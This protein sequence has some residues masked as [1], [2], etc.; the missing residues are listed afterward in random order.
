MDWVFIMNTFKK[1]LI[2]AG[3]FFGA[4]FTPLVEKGLAILILVLIDCFTGIWASIIRRRDAEEAGDDKK[5]AEN[6]ITSRKLRKTIPKFISYAIAL[7]VSLIF[8]THFGF[9]ILT[10]VAFFLASVEVK[11][12]FENLKD[13]TKINFIESISNILNNKLN[14]FKN[15][16]EQ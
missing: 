16:N 1:L 2:Y 8:T 5:I 15:K 14:E 6:L 11:S 12:V 7:L 9:D 13:I 4:Y 10:Y 3:I